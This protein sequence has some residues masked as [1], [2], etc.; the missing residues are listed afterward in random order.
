MIELVIFD[1]DGLLIDTEPFW[2]ETERVVF[3]DYGI[4]ISEEMQHATFGLRTSEQIL[5]WYNYKPWPNADLKEVEKKYNNTILS[6]FEHE[7]ELMKGAM[8]ILDFWRDKGIKMALASSSDMSLI[9]SF[10]NRFELSSYFEHLVS[11]EFEAYGKPHPAVYISTAKKAE[12]DPVR[13][14]A[15]EDSLNGV[16]AAKSARMKAVA[17]PDRKHYTIPGYA[18]ADLKIPD[19][20]SFGEQNYQSLINSHA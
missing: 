16:L 15:F 17:V 7:A 10:I 2:Q 4:E 12:V 1:M 3:A 5:H 11:A 19:L 8:Y 18:I 9:N 14:L 13:C 6:F 20:T